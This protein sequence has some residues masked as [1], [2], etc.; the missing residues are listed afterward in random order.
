VGIKLEIY[1]KDPDI[2]KV[3]LTLI[4]E[5]DG[6]IS[7]DVVDSGGES[8]STLLSMN[9]KGMV[10]HRYVEKNIGIELDEEGRIVSHNK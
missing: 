6:S 7:L 1:K 10:R 9:E 2:K 3:L 5:V 4:K 8:I